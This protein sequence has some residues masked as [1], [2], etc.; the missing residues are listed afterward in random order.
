MDNKIAEV[1]Y[2]THIHA[3]VQTKGEEGTAVGMTLYSAAPKTEQPLDLLNTLQD[4][5]DRFTRS[6]NDPLASPELIAE[7]R[8]QYGSDDLEIDDFNVKVSRADDG[9]W[10]A[11]W[12]WI[13]NE[14]E[15]EEANTEIIEM[16][17]VKGGKFHRPVNLVFT[18]EDARQPRLMLCGRSLEPH[19]Y[20]AT[21]EDANRHTGGRLSKYAC[22]HCDAA[23]RS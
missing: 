23:V 13:A 7:A 22:L 12:V 10:V 15:E 14:H 9:V 17:S 20:F 8:K 4:K 3:T 21:V 1:S 5:L 6:L 16:V 18:S 2:S 11:A 19:N